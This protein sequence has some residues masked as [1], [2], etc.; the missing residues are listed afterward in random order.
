[1]APAGYRN[2]SLTIDA[3]SVLKNLTDQLA[4]EL[5]QP[6]SHSE[7]LR[8]AAAVVADAPTTQIRAAA[9][10]LF[11]QV[12]VN[13]LTRRLGL[14]EDRAGAVGAWTGADWGTVWTEA[15]AAVLIEVWKLTCGIHGV[16]GCRAAE[17]ATN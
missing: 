14:P 11:D 6:I 17:C 12:T 1:M 10:H 8:I 5:D 16:H 4:D 7:A 15:E 2:V 9:E 3:V 13:V